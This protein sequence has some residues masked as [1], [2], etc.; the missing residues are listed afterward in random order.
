MINL[1]QISP[2]DLVDNFPASY[3]SNMNSIKVHIDDLENM[4][5]SASKT[6]KL[7]NLTSVPNGGIEASVITLTATTGNVFSVSPNGGTAVAV[8]TSAGALTAVSIT[9]TGTGSSKSSIVDLDITG[10]LQ[11]TGYTTIN[12]K[13]LFTGANS[14][15]AFKSRVVAITNAMT[16]SGATNPLDISKDYIVYLDCNNSGATLANDS[17]IKLDT[18]NLIEGQIIKFHLLR[19]NIGSQ[20]FFNGATGAE[21]FA[22]VDPTAGFVSIAA[23]TKPEFQPSASPN[24]QSYVLTQWTNIGGG[25]F[26]LVILE[27]KN[28]INVS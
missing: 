8:L 20:K 25:V 19:Q 28:V 10:I 23:G 12:S 26:R 17:E 4:L 1:N 18:S 15:L 3:N 27:S 7:T 2:S 16:G 21:I 5:I 13:I 11:I 22:Y 9:A 14:Q 24:N 6:L